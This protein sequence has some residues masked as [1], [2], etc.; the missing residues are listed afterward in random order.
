MLKS[1]SILHKYE[2]NVFNTEMQLFLLCF[3][4]IHNALSA[5]VVNSESLEKG[6]AYTERT[7]VATAYKKN[8]LNEKR[9]FFF[10]Y[11]DSQ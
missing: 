4:S 1:T 2:Q 9:S 6:N 3:L 7:Y 11:R 5:H 8:T 10:N